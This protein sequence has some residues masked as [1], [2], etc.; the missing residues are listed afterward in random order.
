MCRIFFK[1]SM[2]LHR[3]L[4]NFR[5]LECKDDDDRIICEGE[6]NQQKRKII[7]DNLRVNGMDLDKKKLGDKFGSLNCRF[8]IDERNKNVLDCFSF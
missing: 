8:E 4:I 2:S 5:F 3:M 1:L 6:R 7:V